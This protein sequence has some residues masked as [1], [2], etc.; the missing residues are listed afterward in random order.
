M[1]IKDLLI[2][3]TV[4]QQGSFNR[5]AQQLSYVQSNITSRIQKLEQLLGT[6][7]FHRH[8]RGITLTSDGAQLLPYAQQIISLSDEMKSLAQNEESPRGKLDIAS[9]ETVIQLPLI[10]SQY[11]QRYP[12][13]DL[14]LSTGV[15]AELKDK[16]LQYE[17]DGAF[18]TKEAIS[19]DPALKQVDVFYEKL[20]IISGK[21]NRSFEEIM[22]LPIIRFSDGCGYRA[23][24]DEYLYDHQIIPTKVMELGTLETTLGSVISGLGI[25]YVPYAAIK[26]YEAKGLIECYELPGKYSKITTVFIYRNDQYIPPALKLFVRTVREIHKTLYTKTM[27]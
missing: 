21:K 2:F 20:V 17:L 3:Q 7:L 13:V 5:A 24:L 22:Q 27:N 8:Q 9:V 12:E 16:V 1:N 19:K 25:A 11:A 23:K 6:K 18:V 26:E 15:T 4:A 10:L 14:T